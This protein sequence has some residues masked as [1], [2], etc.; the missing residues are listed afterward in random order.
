MMMK[1]FELTVP[2]GT[3]HLGRKAWQQEREAANLPAAS[4][5]E[6]ESSSTHFSFI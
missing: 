3:V 4:S 2:R 1:D 5:A 6:A